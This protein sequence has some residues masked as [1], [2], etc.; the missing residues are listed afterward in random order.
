MTRRVV[1]TGVGLV[2]ALGLDTESTWSGLLEGRSGVGPITHFDASDFSARIAAE[3]K[4]LDP[5]AYV[6]TKN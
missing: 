5:L 2:S 1:L 3:V 6:D 4:N